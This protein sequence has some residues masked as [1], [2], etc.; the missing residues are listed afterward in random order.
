MKKFIMPYNGPAS[1]MEQMTE[2]QDN[3]TFMGRQTWT[4]KVGTA[5]VAIGAPMAN[6]RA[7]VDD[8]SQGQATDLNRYSII[9]AE[10]MDEALMLVDGHP[11]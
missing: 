1:P 11:I 5:L 9:Q 4:E 3:K 10:S 8:G 6:D 2:E 7:V